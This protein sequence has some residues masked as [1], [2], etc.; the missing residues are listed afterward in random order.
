MSN[1]TRRLL[2]SLLDM[3]G[4]AGGYIGGYFVSGGSIWGAFAGGLLVLAYGILC[5]LDADTK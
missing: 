1:H 4:F 2:R 3:S 5:Y